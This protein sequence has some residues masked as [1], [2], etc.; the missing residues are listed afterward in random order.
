MGFSLVYGG[1]DGV[2]WHQERGDFPYTKGFLSVVLSW[3]FSPFLGG[4][5][6]SIIF[7]LNR[8]CILRRKNSAN[9]AIWS[10]PILLFLTVFINM[11]FVLAKGAKS[12]LQKVWPCTTS[13]GYKGLSYSDCSS[14]PEQQRHLDC[15]CLRRLLRCC[16]QPYLHSHP[17]PQAE[18]GY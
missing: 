14:G 12:D 5:L 6:S 11:M 13:I 17:A 2:L 8:L 3:F 4:I 15:C 18:E 10:L 9:L 16:W 1:F 7:Y